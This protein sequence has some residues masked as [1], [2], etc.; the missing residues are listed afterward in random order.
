LKADWQATSTSM[1]SDRKDGRILPTP[2][3]GPR[4]FIREDSRRR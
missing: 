1:L 3:A 4:K 2:I